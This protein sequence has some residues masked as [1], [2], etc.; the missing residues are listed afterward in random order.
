M[1]L[2]ELEIEFLKRLASEPWIG[3]ESFDHERVARVIELGLVETE[4]LPSGEIEYR[5]TEAGRAAI[6]QGP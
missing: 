4:P 5:I 2:T 1:T 3:T 6:G